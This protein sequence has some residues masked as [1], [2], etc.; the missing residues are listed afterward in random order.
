MKRA[1]AV[2]LWLPLAAAAQEVAPGPGL[3]YV[4][5][6]DMRGHPPPQLLYAEPRIARSGTEGNTPLY[7]HVPRAETR[8]WSRYCGHYDACGHPAYFVS[9]E[10]YYGIY[11]GRAK[12]A[13]PAAAMAPDP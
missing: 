5:V 10:W 2:L 7:L 12:D 9:E 1:M 8:H 11:L 13:P 3:D 6:L 4:G